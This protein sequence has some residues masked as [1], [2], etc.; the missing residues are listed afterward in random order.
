MAGGK[1]KYIDSPKKEFE[2]P[3]K[4]NEHGEYV[5]FPNRAFING[6]DQLRKIANQKTDE[7]Y[8]YLIQILDTNLFKIGVSKNP[9]RRLSDLSSILPFDLKAWAINKVNK[10]YELEQYIIN[11]YKSNL[12][13]NEWFRFD[14][15]EAQDVIILLHN[16][17]VEYEREE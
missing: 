15:H 8:V 7:G 12:I 17:Q 6:K 16:K 13:R 2:L 3:F 10:P 11:E 9:K 14:G 1:S 5:V 4:K